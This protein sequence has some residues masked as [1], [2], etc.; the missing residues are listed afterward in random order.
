M[1]WTVISVVVTAI[2]TCVIAYY[3][4]ASNR[5]ANEMKLQDARY[6]ERL[7]KLSKHHQSELSDL[8]QAITIATLMGGSS[9]T[10][11]VKELIKTFN[12]YYCGNIKIFK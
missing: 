5:L 1:D 9:N 4:Y 7:E 8:Y 10:N 12:Q 11:V 6:Q 3:S 2:A